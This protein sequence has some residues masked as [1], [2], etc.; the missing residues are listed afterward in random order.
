M[1]S[2][3]LC[4]DVRIGAR[5]IKVY[6]KYVHVHCDGATTNRLIANYTKSIHDSNLAV[7]L[8]SVFQNTSAPFLPD[9]MAVRWGCK[10]ILPPTVDAVL[11]VRQEGYINEVQV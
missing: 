10:E 9:E 3:M 2:I 8:V 7:G 11:R 5:R 4:L 6:C 1:L